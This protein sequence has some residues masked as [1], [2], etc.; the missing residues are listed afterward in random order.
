MTDKAK[1]CP[2]CKNEYN[3]GHTPDCYFRIR[4]KT[5]ESRLKTWQTRPIEDA[6]RVE[7]T[8]LRSELAALKKVRVDYCLWIP[9]DDPDTGVWASQCGNEFILEEG[10]PKGNGFIYCPYCG[11]VLKE[12]QT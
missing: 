8:E 1:L 12:E 6:L 10:T 5:E 7:L 2:F 9:V 3:S 4:G 11:K